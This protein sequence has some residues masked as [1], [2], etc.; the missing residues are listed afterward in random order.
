[1]LYGRGRLKKSQARRS[2]QTRAKALALSRL[3]TI[4]DVRMR[5]GGYTGIELKYFDATKA[6]SAISQTWDG[7][8]LDPATYNTLC[9]PGQ[10]DEAQGRDGRRITIKSIQIN[11][12]VYRN[13][14][15]AA[16]AGIDPASITL[17]LVLDTQT[18]GA[19][20][21]AE[22]VYDESVATH[23]ALA[24]RS[25]EH[26]T[27]FR[28]LWKRT[29]TVVD[30]ACFTDGTNTASVSGT[31][32]FFKIYKRVNIPVTFTA[33]GATVAVIGDNSLHI[34]GC[35]TQSECR[36]KYESRC[37]FVG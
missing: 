25:L 30:N 3:D 26:N 18:N 28:I 23:K 7:G 19:Q 36:I 13:T 33:N 29:F 16:G 2:K 4:R 34:I 24:F 9:C 21:N 14:R 11:G 10:S 15:A 8:E 5:T 20:L 37:R 31:G 1:M 22:D 6:D 35:A 27:R 17:A 12:C 32:R